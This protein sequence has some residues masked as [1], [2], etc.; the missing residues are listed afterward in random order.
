LRS[1][2]SAWF[3]TPG[4]T[5]PPGQRQVWTDG[6]DGY[7]PARRRLLE[8]A[9][10]KRVPGLVVLGG[11]V[12]A[13]FVAQLR[14][15]PDDDRSPVIGAEF[16]GTS[17]ASRGQSQSRLDAARADNAHLLVAEA[18]HR[19]SIQFQL[20]TKALRADLRAVQD[21]RNLHSAVSSLGSYAVE[22]GRPGAV[23]A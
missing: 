20:E 22:A 21:I 9:A 16:C 8:A 14:A 19:G 4:E 3:G 17:I 1:R 11:D 10:Q 2:T 13:H 18:R 23:R 5:L 7:A 12:H 6:W 15:N